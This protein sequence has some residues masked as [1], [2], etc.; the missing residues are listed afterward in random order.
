MAVFRQNRAGF[1]APNK[2]TPFSGESVKART[3]I[4]LQKA[5]SKRGARA[6]FKSVV[7]V[8]AVKMIETLNPINAKIF[9]ELMREINQ[10]PL[11][12]IDDL[13]ARVAKSLKEK[14]PKNHYPYN[15]AVTLYRAAIKIGAIK[16]N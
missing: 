6:L 13:A 2:S 8:K 4:V 5:A 15:N 10:N 16:V 12:S 9:A 11:L 7:E 3:G 1:R 14:D